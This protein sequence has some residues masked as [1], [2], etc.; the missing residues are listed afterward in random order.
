MTALQ[1]YMAPKI[2]AL[3]N[4]YTAIVGFIGLVAFVFQLCFRSPPK[5]IVESPAV[6]QVN[7]ILQRDVDGLRDANH[8]W[9]ENALKLEAEI[10]LLKQEN[11]KIRKQAKEICLLAGIVTGLC[12]IYICL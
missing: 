7:G 1:K 12:L 2:S 11:E 6:W 9:F 3:V 5:K 4:F 10:R 8:Q